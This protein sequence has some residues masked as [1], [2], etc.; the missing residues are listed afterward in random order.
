MSNAQL[1][2]RRALPFAWSRHFLW[3]NYAVVS[4][5][6]LVSNKKN[7]INKLYCVLQYSTCS[8]RVV[9]IM[10]HI[11]SRT[12]AL[13]STVARRTQNT[14]VE[15]CVCWQLLQQNIVSVC[16]C[17]F[18]FASSA[19]TKSIFIIIWLTYSR[20]SVMFRCIRILL[21]L[22]STMCLRRLIIV[23]KNYKQYYTVDTAR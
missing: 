19:V 12:F 3:I 1:S 13:F 20:F 8:S 17:C 14:T 9:A 23:P 16:T 2:A 10:K 11:T 21:T 22:R 15:S 18:S 6:R 5:Y 7:F 4:R